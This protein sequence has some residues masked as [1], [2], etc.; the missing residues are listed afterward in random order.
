MDRM[1]YL[2]LGG[3]LERLCTE[4]AH[5]PFADLSLSVGETMTQICLNYAGTEPW[6]SLGKPQ[7]RGVYT[8]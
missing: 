3:C 5:T 1:E 7:P 2:D 8:N 4:R 6:D